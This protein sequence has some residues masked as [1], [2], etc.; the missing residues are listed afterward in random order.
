MKVTRSRASNT[1]PA[2]LEDVFR[3]TGDF[4]R[5]ISFERKLR[6]ELPDLAAKFDVVWTAMVVEEN[7]RVIDEA[8]SLRRKHEEI[9]E[10]LSKDPLSATSGW[11]KS[12]IA[13]GNAVFEVCDRTI[14]TLEDANKDIASKKQKQK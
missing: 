7:D 4:G 13:D 14:K 2:F 10:D 12:M 5:G 9:T 6:R 1:D 11:R 8:K 3:T